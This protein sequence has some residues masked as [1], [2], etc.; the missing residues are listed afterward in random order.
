VRLDQ[1]LAKS[2]KV[3]SREHAKELITSGNVT[4]SGAVETKPSLEVSGDE[5]ITVTDTLKYV[6][7]GG[8][9]LEFA[10]KT[11]GIDVSGK[12]CLDIG[13]STGGFTDCLLQN[14]AEAVICVDTGT[15][16]LDP[17]IREN[18]RVAFYENTDIREF[19]I[20]EITTAMKFVTC[21]VSFISITKILP[22]I[23]ELL[24]YADEAV[25]LIKPQFESEM[26]RREKNGVI[27]DKNVREAAL[28]RVLAAAAQ[29]GLSVINRA[30]S[31]PP[32]KDGNVEYIAHI[33]KSQS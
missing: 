3:K 12:T 30:E 21:D 33:K 7:R 32:G 2:G 31:F 11:F 20:G 27:K 16:Q 15:S 28:E 6:S 4:V 26:K 19:P 25:I 23:A 29:N 1:F 17:K 22:K 5:E 14:G 10:L 18:P 24:E 9:K 13:A 8:L